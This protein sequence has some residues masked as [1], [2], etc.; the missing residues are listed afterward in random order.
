MSSGAAI[1]VVDDLI[2][3]GCQR[4]VHIG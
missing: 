3:R 1:D 2:C 4:R